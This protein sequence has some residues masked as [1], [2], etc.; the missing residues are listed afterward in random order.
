M[1]LKPRLCFLTKG[2]RG[3]G[4]HL[5]GQRNKGGQFIRK[6]EPGSPADMS[7]LRAGDR[8]VEV[9]GENVEN[10]THYQVVNL[11]RAVEHRT[12]LLVVDRET[13][14]Y[15]HSHSLPISEAQA[16][17]MGNLSPRPSP[18][19]TPLASPLPREA[20]PF[21]PCTHLPSQTPSQSPGTTVE[22]RPR[23]CHMVRGEH[24]YGFNLHSNKAHS[25]QFIRSVEANSPAARADLRS[26]DRLV[27]VNGLSVEG[28]KHSEVVGLIH[29]GEKETRLLVVDPHTDDLFKRLGVTPNSSHVKEVYVDEPIVSEPNVDEPIVSE[30]NV[31]EPIANEQL[32]DSAPLTPSP[33]NTLQFSDQPPVVHI[34][35][36]DS[37]TS[38]SPKL[39][40]NGSSGS[41]SSRSSTT[42]SEFSSSDTSIPIPDEEEQKVS[43]PFIESGLR[44]SPTAA[45][46][47][48]R[49]RAKRNKKSAPPMDWSKKQQIFSNL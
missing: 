40:T 32:G 14:D 36:A 23:V 45:E 41:Q 19:P 27:E 15:L 7:G 13:Y 16:M 46:A 35:I 6:V 30:P 38:S 21:S 25:G 3:Y 43:D 8:V 39:R 22:L 1:E 9:N 31:D 12:R 33:T 20:G 28:L 11:I 34:T 44:L 42:Q 37:P 5:H 17:E 26:Q 2:E 24:G 29:E 4:F 49:A 10:E 47:K 18:K 48:E